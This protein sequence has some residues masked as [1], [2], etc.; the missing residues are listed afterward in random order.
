MR[1]ALIIGRFQPFHKAHE[2][3]IKQALKENDSV[4]IAIGS[5]QESRTIKNPFNYEER[6]KMISSCFKDIKIIPCPDFESDK[7]WADY[8]IKKANFNT[9]YSNNEWV[10]KIF[11]KR[12]IIIKKT[13]ENKKISGTKI[14]QMINNNE[15]YKKLIPKPCLDVLKKIDAQRIIKECFKKKE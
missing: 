8:L 14:R 1:N 13:Q 9:V 15:N 4:I 5:S 2:L 11:S 6:K 10:N 7:D 3:L 12:K